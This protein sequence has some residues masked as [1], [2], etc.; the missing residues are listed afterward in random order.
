MTID[1][2]S[3][4]IGDKLPE[5]VRTT[6]FAEWNRYAAVNDEFIP[7]HM[8]DDAG[9]AAGN[10]GGAFG[11]GNLRLAYLTNM[12][13]AWIGDNGQICSLSVKYRSM[14][15]KGDVLRAVGE[16]VGTEIVDGAALVHLKV[17]VVDQKGTSTTPGTATVML[18]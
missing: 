12:L 3:I 16:V 7:I 2:N 4:A 17:D 8:D 5:Y 6:G 9:R 11:M 10:E 14:N 13:R 18:A 15:Q 1:F